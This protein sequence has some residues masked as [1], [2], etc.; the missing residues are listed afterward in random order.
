M[1]TAFVVAVCGGRLR[2]QL[3]SEL[4][5]YLHSLYHSKIQ[6]HDLCH[7]NGFEK[8]KYSLFVW[9]FKSNY[10]RSAALLFP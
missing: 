1:H 7:S 5:A 2:I 4:Y 9:C 6:S 8:L 3:R 10:I